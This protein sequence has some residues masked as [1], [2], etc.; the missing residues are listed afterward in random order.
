[1]RTLDRRSY[2]HPAGVS[3]PFVFFRRNPIQ[4]L[5]NFRYEDA[6]FSARNNYSD[7]P[8]KPLS[9]LEVFIGSVINKSGVQTR[10]QRDQSQKLAD[11]FERIAS[12]I[13]HQMHRHRKVEVPRTDHKTGTETLELCLAC[14][15][16]AGDQNDDSTYRRRNDYGE[17]KS[18]RIVAA[19]ALLA[20]LDILEKG[21]K[22]S[23][24][25][26]LTG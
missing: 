6:I 3:S 12:W 15:Q 24:G 13:T 21:Q 8:I 17:L 10:R 18:F 11:E 2:A 5:T 1:M 7:H 23:L 19:C 4:I 25:S 22:Q 9:E 14:F 26:G 20:E 16:V